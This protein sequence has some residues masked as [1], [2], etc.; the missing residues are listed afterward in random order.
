MNAG[1]G[2]ISYATDNQ[3]PIDAN[4][5]SK[6]NPG[7]CCSRFREFSLMILSGCLKSTKVKTYGKKDLWEPSSLAYKTELKSF[8]NP[9]LF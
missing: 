4:P 6:F 8:A 9:T 2:K 3:G 5:G 7:S 1:P